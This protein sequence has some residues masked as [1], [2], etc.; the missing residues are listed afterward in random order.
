MVLGVPCDEDKQRFGT[1]SL[2]CTIQRDDWDRATAGMLRM[3]YGEEP[4]ADVPQTDP[5]AATAV[6]ERLCGER[7]HAWTPR[8][9]VWAVHALA[10]GRVLTALEGIAAECWTPTSGD[11]AWQVPTDGTGYQL[12]TLPDGE[13]A[14]ALTQ[15]PPS[16]HDRGRQTTEPSVVVEIDLHDGA[17]R[18]THRAGS[19]SIVASRADGWWALRGT[20][21]DTATATLFGPD[22]VRASTVRV[23]GYDVFNHYP[24]RLS[25]RRAAMGLHRRPPGHRSRRDR[26]PRL[27]DLQLGRAGDPARHGRRGAGEA[28]ATGERASGGAALPRACRSEPARDRHPGRSSA[29]LFDRRRAAGGTARVRPAR[30]RHR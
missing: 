11:C 4:C 15:T 21:Y 9:A 27:R 17:V 25:G 28:V 10:D 1:T 29:G 30:R 8:G 19:P 18:T 13:T 6:I 16:F 14:L 3:P 23:G 12:T 5:G 24:P 22:G 20:R 26:R 2:A 7:G